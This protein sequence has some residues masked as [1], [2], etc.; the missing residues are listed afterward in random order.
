LIEEIIKRIYEFLAVVKRPVPYRTG[1]IHTS[2]EIH[3]V[4]REVLTIS[5]L[6]LIY[7]STSSII[8]VSLLG[9]LQQ[10]PSTKRSSQ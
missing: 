5:G 10:H 3:N 1:R 2:P 7:Y 9:A 4:E 6:G 8:V